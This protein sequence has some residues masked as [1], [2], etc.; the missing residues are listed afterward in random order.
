MLTRVLYAMTGNEAT[1]GLFELNA[2][3]R[4]LSPRRLAGD[5]RIGSDDETER[6]GNAVLAWHLQAEASGRHISDDATNDAIGIESDRAA[7]EHPP[8]LRIPVL[9]HGASGY[10]KS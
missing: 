10:P 1:D 8:S 6:V 4:S 9:W 7:L 5:W 3:S 2:D